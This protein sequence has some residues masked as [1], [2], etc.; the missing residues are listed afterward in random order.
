MLRTRGSLAATAVP[1]LVAAAALM[2]VGCKE[3]GIH[4]DTGHNTMGLYAKGYNRIIESV[5]DLLERYFQNTPEAGPTLETLT[6]NKSSL[7]SGIGIMEL[8]RKE[9]QDSFAEAKKS[10]SKELEQLGALADA[11]WGASTEI[12]SL[13]DDYCKYIAA[14]DFK[15]DKGAK[16]KEYHPKWLAAAEKYD[17]ARNKFSAE[18]DKIEDAQITADIE[19]HEADKS[20]SYWFRQF[21]HE[22]KRFVDKVRADQVNVSTHYSEL[23]PVYNG[24]TEFS[25][26]KGSGINSTFK[27]YQSSADR[28]FADVKKL[29]RAVADAKDDEGKKKAVEDKFD[30]LVSGYNGLVSMYNGLTS[31]ESANALE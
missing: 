7:C 3:K 19:K 15:D 25:Q 16:A 14:E 22:A 27:A 18:L 26:G 24:L 17:A 10:A 30:S 9:V 31:L 5:P 11:L 20:Y 21:N 13:S 12:I 6:Q 8:Y 2:V 23:E 28:F 4:G 1:R 29:N